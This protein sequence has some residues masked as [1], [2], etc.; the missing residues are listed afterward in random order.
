MTPNICFYVFAHVRHILQNF[1]T[2]TY[3]AVPSRVLTATP[4][5]PVTLSPKILIFSTP[6][7][8]WQFSKFTQPLPPPSSG[9]DT[10]QRI[11]RRFYRNRGTLLLQLFHVYD[12][13]IKYI[14]VMYQMRADIFSR[15][16]SILVANALLLLI[17][18]S[19][20]C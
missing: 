10:M 15:L 2:C 8:V 17:C 7:P 19:C 4:L 6:P 20:E 1:G 13:C 5:E 11:I 9:G 14:Q 18:F 16:Q 3:G 12:T